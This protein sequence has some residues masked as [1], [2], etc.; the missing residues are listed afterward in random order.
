MTVFQLQNQIYLDKFTGCYKKIIIINRL[1]EDDSL[2]S[3]IKT[4]RREKL[5]EFKSFDCC[6]GESSCIYAFINPQNNQFIDMD[7]IDILFSL[8]INKGYTVQYSMTK[9]ISNNSNSNPNL[10]C[11]ISKN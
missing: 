10:I 5:S 8:L 4:I 6:N 7:N 9:L 3:L 2:K 1:P 11:F